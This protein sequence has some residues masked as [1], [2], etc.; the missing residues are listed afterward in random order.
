[1]VFA[2]NETI[3]PHLIRTADVVV[4]VRR[5]CIILINILG[6]RRNDICSYFDYNYQADQNYIQDM[7]FHH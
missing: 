1:M 6:G 2:A 4:G 7:I 3:R 5:A